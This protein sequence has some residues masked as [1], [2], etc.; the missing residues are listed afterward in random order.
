MKVSVGNSRMDKKW[1]LVEMSL[2]DFRDHIF[3][4][5]KTAETMEQ[6]KKLSKAQRDD[7]KDIGGG[8]P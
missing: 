7:I 3:T 2:E 4:T 6:Y 5:H 1:N 8:P